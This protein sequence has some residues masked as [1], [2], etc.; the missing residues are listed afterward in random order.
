LSIVRLL[1]IPPANIR[2]GQ[3][4][5]KNQDLLKLSDDKIRNMRGEEISYIF[6]NPLVS[7]N[8]I[9]PVVE[10]IAENLRN[11]RAMSLEEA[12]FEAIRLMRL[13]GISDAELRAFSYPHLFSGGMRQ[14]VMIAIALSC[15]PSLLIAEELVNPSTYKT[16]SLL[17]NSL[18][19]PFNDTSETEDPDFGGTT[20]RGTLLRR[21]LAYAIDREQIVEQVFNGWG[22]VPYSVI[23]TYY[24]GYNQSVQP[25]PY[26]PVY[27]KDILTDLGY[28]TSSPL[29]GLEAYLPLIS[30]SGL[31]VIIISALI[32]RRFKK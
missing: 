30:F 12:I 24:W 21:A 27:V 32:W 1:A 10:Q 4:V 28:R 14:R 15:N 13:V 26:D 2:S 20:T 18:I 6:N 25:Y 11:H 31:V 5:F 7:L 22:R 9:H 23:A 19:A 8:P 17:I 3:I 16:E 29:P